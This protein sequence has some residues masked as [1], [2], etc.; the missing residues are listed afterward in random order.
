MG[1]RLKTPTV[2]LHWY[3][4]SDYHDFDKTLKSQSITKKDALC[5]IH[6][7]HSK[8]DQNGNKNH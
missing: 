2:I 6:S 1:S 8:A 4:S 3:L 7:F 5:E